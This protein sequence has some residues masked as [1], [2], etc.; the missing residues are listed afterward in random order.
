MSIFSQLD[1]LLNMGERLHFLSA[2]AGAVFG[3]K[4]GDEGPAA[5]KAAYW[6]F[7]AGK[8]D[9]RRVG[10]LLR[11]LADED[12]EGATLFIEHALWMLENNGSLLG[13]LEAAMIRNAYFV[14]IAKVDE[15]T[16]TATK[17]GTRTDKVTYDLPD[18]A[19]QTKRKGTAETKS[20]IMN[21]GGASEAL[22]LINEII[23]RI[24]AE[25]EEGK[26]KSEAFR[27]TTT[28]F[29]QGRGVPMRKVGDPGFMRWIE[30]AAGITASQAQ[31]IFNFIR[32]DL[33]G[34][35]DT[36]ANRRRLRRQQQIQQQ[37]SG[38]GWISWMLGRALRFIIQPRLF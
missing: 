3:D 29:S 12:E 13:Q 23:G 18:D 26:S 11:N 21:G 15:L 2:I 14:Y 22:K 24:K 1:G 25:I 38:W 7:G 10:R 8:D 20:D 4:P 31:R 27:A 36:E 6:F 30:K 5:A 28:W 34:W 37:P 32:N 19:D 16:P 33:A 35:I 9:E 17:T